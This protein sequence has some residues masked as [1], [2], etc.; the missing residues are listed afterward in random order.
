MIFVAMISDYLY[1]LRCA[2]SKAF[3][4][5]EINQLQYGIVVA[6]RTKGF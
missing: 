1:I 6:G 3:F 2:S 4:K 5:Q